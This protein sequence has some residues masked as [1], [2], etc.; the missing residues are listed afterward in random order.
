MFDFVQSGW[1][2]FQSGRAILHSH[3]QR[4]RAWITFCPCQHL[5]LSVT[6][7]F[8]ILTALLFRK[9]ATPVRYATY[10][11]CLLTKY[12]DQ[13]LTS[14]PWTIQIRFSLVYSLNPIPL[15]PPMSMDVRR[16]NSLGNMETE[17][18]NPTVTGE[19]RQTW[20]SLK[21]CIPKRLSLVSDLAACC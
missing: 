4:M 7:S 13:N 14:E 8:E 12:L 19:N 21:K 6:V 20:S 18:K 10:L 9:E 2:I 5:A 1:A 15:R 17:T 11:L 16:S 3:Q